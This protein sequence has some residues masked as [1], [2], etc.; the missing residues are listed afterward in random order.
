M[1][2]AAPSLPKQ[3]HYTQDQSLNALFFSLRT[4]FTVFYSAQREK[5]TIRPKIPVFD[6]PHRPIF[7]LKVTVYADQKCHRH[8]LTPLRGSP[9]TTKPPM[10]IESPPRAL[11]NRRKP[12]K[13]ALQALGRS[14]HFFLHCAQIQQYIQRTYVLRKFPR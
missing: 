4:T 5:S 3:V 9:E 11:Q 13:S 12:E 2:T 1:A 10:I 8:L 14:M 7:W 6:R